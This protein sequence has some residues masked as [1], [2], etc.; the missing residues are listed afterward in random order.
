MRA[1]IG[2]ARRDYKA[3][4]L[5]GVLPLFCALQACVSIDETRLT[6]GVFDLATPANRFIN[7]ENRARVILALR[8]RELCPNGYSRSSE[9]RIVDAKGIE[10]MIWRIR[11]ND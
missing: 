7:S 11:C 3:G 2:I 9:S 8:A 10:T 5:A 4:F 1:L 6:P